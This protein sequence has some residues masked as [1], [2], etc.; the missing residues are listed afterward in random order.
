MR[1]EC[2]C[3]FTMKS[4][5][6]LEKGNT[7]YIVFQE[8][9]CWYA[10]GLEFNIVESGDDPQ[11]ALLLLFGALKGYVASAQKIKARPGILNQ[12]TDPEYEALWAALNGIRKPVKA[13]PPVFAF[14][15][16]ALATA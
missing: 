2:Y 7:R 12:A 5:N 15:Q 14:G 6:T 1:V 3:L 4:K 16:T 11:E 9:D 13:M 8:D 10:V